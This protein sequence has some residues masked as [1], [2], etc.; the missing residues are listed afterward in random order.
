MPDETMIPASSFYLY[1]GSVFSILG[2]YILYIQYSIN[3]FHPFIDTADFNPLYVPDFRPEIELSL[4]LKALIVIPLFSLLLFILLGKIGSGVDKPAMHLGH[5]VFIRLVILLNFVLYAV[6][7]FLPAVSLLTLVYWYSIALAVTLFISVGKPLIFRKFLSVF[8]AVFDWSVISICFLLSLFLAYK[9]FLDVAF[10]KNT[11]IPVAVE[12]SYV[13]VDGISPLQFILT[14]AVF[15]AVLIATFKAS[16]KINAAVQTK[17]IVAI[18]DVLVVVGIVMS[19]GIVVG[20]KNDV[21]Y[22]IVPNYN[23]IVAPINDVLGGKTLLVNIN[24]Q[25]GVLMIYALS[26][27]FKFIPLS[28]T[29]FFWINFIV[30]I[31]GYILLYFIMKRLAGW[32][33]LLGIFL[34]LEHHHFSQ[35]LPIL[36]FSQVSFLRFGWWVVILAYLVLIKKNTYH[37]WIG[38]L[39]EYLLV[40]IAVFWGFDVGIYVLG[41]YLSYSVVSIFL[42]KRSFGQ[43][44]QDASI[45]LLRLCFV[46]FMFY[47]AISLFTIIRAGTFPDWSMFTGTASQFANGWGMVKM[48]AFGIHILFLLS[49][50]L[51]FAFIFYRA[52]IG[53]NPSTKE[54]SSRL[55]I[56][57]FVTAYG[58][59]QFS[60]YVGRSVPGNLHHIILPMI[61]IGCIVVTILIKQINERRIILKGRFQ[62]MSV[63]FA[64]L[65]FIAFSITTTIA[66]VNVLNT[67]RKKTPIL[68]NFDENENLPKYQQS[69][70]AINTYLAGK[71]V[72]SRRIAIL[73][74]KDSFFLIK[75]RSVNLVDSNN[76]DYFVLKSQFGSLVRQLF[77][78]N[79]PLVFTDHEAGYPHIELLQNQLSQRYTYSKNIGFLDIW[80]RK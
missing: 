26:V 28:Y 59:L 23:P 8:A 18:V 51:V 80:V 27:L 33:A 10:V 3:N 24:S 43:K 61:L 30:T 45:R 50:L 11:L 56:M 35:V 40:G 21:L 9:I 14:M 66:N 72:P 34:I 46:L 41:A 78:E 57:A 44:V 12:Y 7:L 49:Y 60:Y 55:P 69:I 38:N 42:E 5:R 47:L 54:E 32:G 29:A 58:I 62:L 16:Q 19:V 74:N 15:A 67:Y 13:F 77:K 76:T 48:P 64:L 20:N 73:S 70:T 6:L 63:S 71:K 37:S 2:Y 79:P 1:L 68:F 25:Y 75:T 52:I 22:Y 39:L 17:D 31:T 36:H 65:I 53:R 4:Y